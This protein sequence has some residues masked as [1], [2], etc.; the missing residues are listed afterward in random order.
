L[1][2]HHTDAGGCASR[3]HIGVWALRLDILWN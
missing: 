3:P 1:V 2:L